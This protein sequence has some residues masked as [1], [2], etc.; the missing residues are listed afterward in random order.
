MTIFKFDQRRIFVWGSLVVL[1]LLFFACVYTD[2]DIMCL[3]D[4]I[5]A[6]N[7]RNTGISRW[8]R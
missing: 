6:L 7:D 1:A 8:G 3:N 2:Q 5:V 4:Q